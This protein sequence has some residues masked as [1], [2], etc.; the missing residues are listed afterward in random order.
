MRRRHLRMYSKSTRRGFRRNLAVVRYQV[1]E[2]LR[3]QWTF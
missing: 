2:L 3:A 1:N